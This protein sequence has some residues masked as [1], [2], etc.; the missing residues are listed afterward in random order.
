MPSTPDG[1]AEGRSTVF[2]A[3]APAMPHFLSAAIGNSERYALTI[4]RT[5]APLAERIEIARDS[6]SRRR[7][8]LG[9]DGLDR[10][11]A[12]VIAP[13]QGVHTFGMR[14]PIDIVAVARDGKVVKIRRNVQP[15]RIVIAWSAFA[16]IELASG[17]VDR[18]QLV[19]GDRLRA[20]H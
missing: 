6:E 12:F 19:I 16:I 7:G 5:G 8:L 13:C 14:F 2:A 9:R 15:R 3:R 20:Q 4:A 1:R 17:S 11:S 10:G 18:S